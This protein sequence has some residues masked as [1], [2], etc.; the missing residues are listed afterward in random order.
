MRAR[1]SASSRSILVAASS[2]RWTSSRTSAAG[3]RLGLSL[4]AGELGGNRGL[5]GLGLLGKLL[6]SRP[7]FRLPLQPLLDASRGHG[8]VPPLRAGRAAAASSLS[9][10]LLAKRLDLLLAGQRSHRPAQ[11]AGRTARD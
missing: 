2:P 4:K 3:R 11:A 9:A 5:L 7:L 1:V 8:P 6:P 10:T